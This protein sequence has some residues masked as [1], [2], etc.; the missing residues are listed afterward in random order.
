MKE[1][2]LGTLSKE[3]ERLFSEQCENWSLAKTNFLALETVESKRFE[4]ANLEFVV[5]FN[6]S[7]IGS[8]AAKVDAK[9]IQE[10]KCFLCLSHLPA[11]QK[12]VSVFKNETDF[13]HNYMILVNPFPIFNKHLTIPDVDHTDQRIRSRVGD[14]LSLAKAL[15][16]YVLFYNGPKCGASAPDHMHFQAGNKGFMP[17]EREFDAIND[18]CGVMLKEKNRVRISTL[19][20]IAARTFV[21]RSES[22]E[23]IDSLFK[24]FYDSFALMMPDEVEPMMNILALT[25]GEEYILILF[26]RKQHRPSQFFAEGDENLL[27]SPAS[28]DLGGVFITPQEKDFKKIKLSDINDIIRQITITDDMFDALCNSL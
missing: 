25:K 21:F 26:P 11:E 1:N 17:L 3:V 23:E 15:T 28:V 12:G 8:S 24:E 5:Q 9:S 10:R 13:S 16:D 6:P 18:A 14:M 22:K 7:R 19:T 27:I 20:G 2:V 4:D